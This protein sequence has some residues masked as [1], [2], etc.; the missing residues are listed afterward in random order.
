MMTDIKAFLLSIKLYLYGAVAAILLGL[1]ALHAIDL[2]RVHTAEANL[3]TA[4]VKLDVS[5]ASITDLQTKLDGITKQLKLEQDANIART[6]ATAD[7]LKES[8]DSDKGKI[9]LEAK[10]KSR[11]SQLHCVT[12]KDLKDAY[13]KAGA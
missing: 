2:G 4:A 6:K 7:A 3:N 8:A 9:D 13:A 1:V 12:P 5:N 10:L 11:P